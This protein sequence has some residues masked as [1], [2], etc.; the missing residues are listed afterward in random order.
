M[1]RQKVEDDM[2]RAFT[3]SDATRIVKAA[4]AYA[5]AG[6]DLIVEYGVRQS[7]EG[8]DTADSRSWQEDSDLSDG[9]LSIHDLRETIDV[10]FTIDLYLYDDTGGLIGNADAVWDGRQWRVFDPFAA[11]SQQPRGRA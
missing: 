10:G 3:S 6:P 4:R 9:P 2:K 8:I 1:T 5:F 7:A 11:R